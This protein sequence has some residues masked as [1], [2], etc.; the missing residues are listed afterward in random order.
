MTQPIANDPEKYFSVLAETALSTEDGGYDRL[1][2]QWERA[3]LIATLQRTGGN[4]TK[5]AQELKIMHY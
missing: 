1:Q 2:R 5:A 4:K 3:L